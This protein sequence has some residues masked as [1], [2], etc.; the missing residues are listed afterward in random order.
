MQIQQ[1]LTLLGDFRSFNFFHTVLNVFGPRKDALRGQRFGSHDKV[2]E[3]MHFW[4]KE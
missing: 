2:K 4:V 1:L 3:A